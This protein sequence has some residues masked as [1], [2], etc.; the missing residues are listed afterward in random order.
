MRYRFL[1]LLLWIVLSGCQ[2]K[3]PAQ[4][5]APQAAAPA[6]DA[7]Q[8]VRE[9]LDLAQL[10]AQNERSMSVFNYGAYNVL[11]SDFAPVRSDSSNFSQKWEFFIYSEPYQA[12]IKFEVSSMA[13]SK[14]EGKVRGYV[15]RSDGSEEYRISETLKDGKWSASGAPFALDFGAYRLRF[16]DGTFHVEGTFERGSFEYDIPA[17]FWKPDTGTVYFG[18]RPKDFFR[19]GVLTYHR[20]ATGTVH[21]DGGAV[22]VHGNVYGNYYVMTKGIHEVFDEVAD[23]RKVSDDLLVEFRYYV[24][25]HERYD[26]E[27]FGF[28]FAAFEGTPVF[29]STQIER[30]PLDRW[31]DEDHYGYLIDARQRIVAHDGSNTARFEML[32]A[33][34]VPSDPYADLPS[35][36]RNI[37]MQFAKPIEYSIGVDW[38][39]DLDVDGYRARIPFHSNYS[40]TRLR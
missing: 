18:N 4:N 2:S 21:I 6:G 31:L 19:Y 22:P 28:A 20:E 35:F 9:G 23:F 32:T 33:N 13:F 3:D 30:T 14:N 16:A 8:D 24:P 29:E 34:P 10:A 38:Q 17:H 15:K 27:P 39:I 40:M 25:N 37:A 7:T 36:K 12:R 5:A 26:A 11:L 1:L